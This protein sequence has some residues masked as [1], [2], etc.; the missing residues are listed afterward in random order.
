MSGETLQHALVTLI[1]LSAM[2][3]IFRRIAGFVGVSGKQTQ[4][5]CPSSKGACGG[6]A[7]P[8]VSVTPQPLTLMVKPPA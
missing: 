5:A 7:R 8:L 4:C 6:S 3:V 2:V 1:A